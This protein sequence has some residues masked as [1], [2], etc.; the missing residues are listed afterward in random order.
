MTL[1]Y[2]TF[3]FQSISIVCMSGE[4]P[5]STSE[6]GHDA[7]QEV[8]KDWNF[9]WSQYGVQATCDLYWEKY[10]AVFEGEIVASGER[11]TLAREEGVRKLAEKGK[12]VPAERLVVGYLGW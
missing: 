9:L 1:I 5:L 8:V 11:E 3:V 2:L 10:L 7:G 12:N 4:S 6:L